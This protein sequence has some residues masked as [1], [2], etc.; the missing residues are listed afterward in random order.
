MP[1]FVFSGWLSHNECLPLVH[2]F[3]SHIFGLQNIGFT[4]LL[5]LSALHPLVITFDLLTI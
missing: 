1:G 4:P 2:P 5:S 3:Y